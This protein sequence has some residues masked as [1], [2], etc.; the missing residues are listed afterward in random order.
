MLSWDRIYCQQGKVQ[1]NVLP[2]AIKAAGLFNKKGYKS[3][4]DLACGTGR[5]SVYFAEE[6]FKVY[7]GDIS[8]NGLAIARQN[9]LLANVNVTFD[10]YDMKAVPFHDD[11]FDAVFCVWSI[12]LGTID[13]I[14]QRVEEIFRVLKYGGTV[15]TD[16]ISIADETWGKGSQIE[17]DTF[18]GAMPGL[19]DL[20]EHYS[21]KE[22]LANLFSR[23]QQVTIQ[24]ADQFYFD[25]LGQKFTIKA[26]D[27]EAVK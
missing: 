22:E 7:A 21:T 16:F 19:P 9:V 12:G 4:L 11:Y 13:E 8:E 14:R 25:T 23:F 15:I 24:E 1:I 20:I 27:I 18:Q 6:G 10:R 26:L 5:H 2:K 17:N 3:I